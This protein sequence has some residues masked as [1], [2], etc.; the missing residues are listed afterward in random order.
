MNTGANKTS[1]SEY[2][3]ETQNDGWTGGSVSHKKWLSSGQVKQAQSHNGVLDIGLD[4]PE[5]GG[6][7]SSAGSVDVG[8]GKR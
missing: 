3:G 1:D 5:T 6:D 4:S 7:G 2:G 8:I